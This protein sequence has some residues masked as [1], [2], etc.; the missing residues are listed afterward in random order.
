MFVRVAVLDPLPVFRRGIMTA[1]GDLAFEPEEP[2]D[3]MAWIRDEGRTVVLL[4]L[5]SSVDW[6]L[7]A[8]LHRK[9][10]GVLVIALLGEAG[11][12]EYVRALTAGATGAIPRDA[13]P[14]VV[15]EAFDAALNGKSILPIDVLRALTSSGD[16]K[17]RHP[18]A[19]TPQ[20]IDWLRQLADGLTVVELASSAG[21]SER[22]MFRLLRNV[23]TRWASRNA[24]RRSC[25]LATGAGCSPRR[26]ARSHD[27][28]G[29]E[30]DRV[31]IER[32]AERDRG[33]G[34]SV[35]ANVPIQDDAEVGGTQAGRMRVVDKVFP[36]HVHGFVSIR[37][38]G[39]GRRTGIRP[40]AED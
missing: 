26:P 3:L 28:G 1:L 11:L 25:A 13:P 30:R 38:T 32:L 31:W 10:G 36:D 22:M 35:E 2:N 4:S 34:G 8:D 16:Q 39:T 12:A 18:D 14:E 20:E 29:D 7:L 15:R 37:C 24:P 19:P 5:V 21:Y 9:R 40:V 17:W 33:T 27:C 6:S 23:Y